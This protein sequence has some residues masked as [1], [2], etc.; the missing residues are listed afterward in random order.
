MSSMRA[1]RRRREGRAEASSGGLLPGRMRPGPRRRQPR[2]A[3]VAARAAAR[4]V[5][6]LP[7]VLKP[8]HSNA[9]PAPRAGFPGSAVLEGLDLVELGAG[10]GRPPPRGRR[11][12]PA[13]PRRRPPR[14]RCRRRYPEQ[15]T[16]PESEDEHHARDDGLPSPV[17]RHV[18]AVS[19]VLMGACGCPGPFPKSVARGPS[20]SDRP[21][22]DARTHLNAPRPPKLS[23]ERNWTWR[24]IGS[25][26]RRRRLPRGLNAVIRAV[27]RK[28][29]SGPRATSRRVPRRLARAARGRARMA[30]DVQQCAGILPRGGT[31]LGSSRTNPFKVEGGVELDQGEPRPRRRRR[32]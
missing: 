21:G 4:W 2:P 19:G 30:L 23:K 16:R 27:V 12:A 1:E 5:E 18:R 15:G 3:V 13:P 6:D 31:I 17:L 10:A 22:V 9:G 32:A 26:H 7:R 11:D 25:A 28:G 24:R 20:L 29:R 8:A 14:R